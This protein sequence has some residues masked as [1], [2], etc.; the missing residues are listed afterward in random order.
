MTE[1]APDLA[2]SWDLDPAHTRPG[3]AARLAPETG[4]IPAGDRVRLEPDVLPLKR[5]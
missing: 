5:A 4:G 3:F 2:G 1:A